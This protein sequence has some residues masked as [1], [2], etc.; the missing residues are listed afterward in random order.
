LNGDSNPGY[1][2]NIPHEVVRNKCAK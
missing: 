2:A 1:P